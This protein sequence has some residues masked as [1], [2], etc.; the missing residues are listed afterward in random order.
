M[1]LEDL[2]K[3]L[4]D[5]EAFLQ[6]EFSKMRQDLGEIKQ[7]FDDLNRAIE[8]EEAFLAD[9]RK[10]LDEEGKLLEKDKVKLSVQGLIKEEG[11]LDKAIAKVHKEI[12]KITEV[13]SGI[14]SRWDGRKPL[15]ELHKM[16][17]DLETLKVRWGHIQDQKVSLQNHQSS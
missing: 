6:D 1:A 17:A 8:E 10:D 13:T 4:A 12:D 9:I 15:A 3:L 14:S 11:D 5:H 7:S 16:V 2:D